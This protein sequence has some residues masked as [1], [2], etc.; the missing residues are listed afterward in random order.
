MEY[1]IYIILIKKCTSLCCTL[2]FYF[3]LLNYNIGKIMPKGFNFHRDSV[4]IFQYIFHISV[5][6]VSFLFSRYR[7]SDILFYII[8][9]LSRKVSSIRK[10]RINVRDIRI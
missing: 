2:F 4:S 6:F 7:L 5:I 1:Y 3:V 9:I 10:V 8:R